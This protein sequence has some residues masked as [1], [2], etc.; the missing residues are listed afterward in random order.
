M[1]KRSPSVSEP[2]TLKSIDIE[3]NILRRL[4]NRSPPAG[5]RAPCSIGVFAKSFTCL[6]TDPGQRVA[7]EHVYHAGAAEPGVHHDHARGLLADLAD[8]L[9]VLAALDATQGFERGVGRIWG[10]HGA[11]RGPGRPRGGGG[12]R[13]V[14]RS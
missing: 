7:D 8:D 10:R 3:P 12:G 1:T 4:W 2:D 5:M 11:G 13:A 6:S 9:G 14:R